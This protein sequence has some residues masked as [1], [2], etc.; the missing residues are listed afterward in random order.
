M[1]N[2]MQSIY[3]KLILS[4]I[5]LCLFSNVAFAFGIFISEQGIMKGNQSRVLITPL[6]D[7]IDLVIQGH[8]EDRAE[9]LLWLIPVPNISNIEQYPVQANVIDSAVLDELSEMSK[10]KFEG[11]CEG[12]P[13]MEVADGE[14]KFA[15]GMG[16]PMPYQVFP[17]PPTSNGGELNEYLDQV[18]SYFSSKN[19][20]MPSELNDLFTWALDQNVMFVIVELTAQGIAQNPK[21]VT[22][23]LTLK[24]PT[25]LD[26]K[27]YLKSFAYSTLGSMQSDIVYWILDQERFKSAN[28]ATIEAD[29]NQV[30]FTAADQTNYLQTLDVQAFPSQS[31]KFF[32][33]Y[34][35]QVNPATLQSP[36]LIELRAEKNATYLTR[37]RTR[38]T[39]TALKTTASILNFIPNDTQVP[40]SRSH[41]IPGFQCQSTAPD[42]GVE[43]QRVDLDT[44]DQS[45]MDQAMIDQT[46]NQNENLDFTLLFDDQGMMPKASSASKSGG[47][48][49]SHYDHFHFE[50]IS[51]FLM[52]L[53]GFYWIYRKFL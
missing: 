48:H 27:V 20:P 2:D 14:Q 4:M 45:S 9:K 31:Q 19:I 11:S 7:G 34:A 50:S 22:L 6:I 5:S 46:I 26:A 24:A 1:V 33:E 53:L 29:F 37:L 38:F 51:L 15:G 21:D 47:C 23:E 36:K 41:R 3:S 13:N 25:T 12:T 16:S 17:L 30:Q 8:Y 39:T 43:D 49:Q 52:I 10:P 35:G 18:G 32:V 44:P 40:Y 28:F 42:L